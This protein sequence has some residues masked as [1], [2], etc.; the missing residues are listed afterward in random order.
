MK[1]GQPVTDKSYLAHSQESR[2]RNEPKRTKLIREALNMQDYQNGRSERSLALLIET[3]EAYRAV[4]TASLRLAGCRV[5]TASTAD[6][7][8][9]VLEKR[10]YDLVV[11]GVSSGDS[12][13]R[14]EV[15]SE[16]RLLTEVP[17]SSST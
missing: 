15:I 12:S 13:R 3:D 8:L 10:S 5:D 7:A 1:V 11:W 17:L 16:V 6:A 9:S 2:S 4:I 14:C